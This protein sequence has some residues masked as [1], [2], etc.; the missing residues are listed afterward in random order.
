MLKAGFAH[1]CITPEIGREIPGLF[2]Q[3]LALG[4]ADD[5]FVR[6]VVVDD[7]TCCAALVQTD[8]IALPEVLVRE[9][10]ERAHQLCGIEPRQCLIAATHTHSGGPVFG[11]FL[12]EPDPAYVSF[13]AAQ[14]ASAIAE[15]YRRRQDV[16]VGIDTV[17]AAD[18]A[19][20]RRFR[21]ENGPE[22]THPG[23]GNPGIVEPA[24]PE[25][26]T[27]TVVGFRDPGTH[28]PVGG[29]VHFACHATHMNGLLYSADYPRWVVDTLQAVYGK[30]FGVVYLNGACGDVTQ[31]DNRG[32][33]PLELGPYWCERTGRGV[34]GA[35]L[36]ALARMD[37]HKAAAVAC[38][39]MFVR[40]GIRG[41][42]PAARKAARALLKKKAVTA[43]DVETIYARELLE[44]EKMRKAAPS[45]RLEIMGV[46]IA[47]VLFWGVPAEFFQAYAAEVSTKSP[48]RHTCCVELANGY[49]G[50]IC[51]EGAFPDGGYETRTARSSFLEPKAGAKVST[52]AQRL[53]R[54]M[55][56]AGAKDIAK[57]PSRRVWPRFADAQALDGI[58]QIKKKGG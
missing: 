56:E 37:S 6:A 22:M 27:V 54:R 48:F 2:E 31:V 19:F 46:R 11:G 53:A 57:L 47:D 7:G 40:A 41:S 43:E 34:S 51:T 32:A 23:K 44:V 26:P 14:T 18:F 42:T 28:R 33:R 25:D 45:R 38:D 5:L 17:A 10:R 1:R 30:D 20:N 50:Y 12:S 52:A 9:A 55:F 16:L 21:M 29:V 8:A 24:G 4:V 39:S 3:R 35:A 13:V 15:A 36:V 49:Q 58:N